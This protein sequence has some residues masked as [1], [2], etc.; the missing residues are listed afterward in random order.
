MKATVLTI[1]PQPSEREV[2][3]RSTP[4]NPSS[5]PQ[6]EGLVPSI[7]SV[8]L[9]K[10]L[11]E[12]EVRQGTGVPQLYRMEPPPA[13][14]TALI[15][16]LWS[17]LWILSLVLCAVVVK[18]L[19]SQQAASKIGTAQ[20]QSI[21]NLTAEIG[22]QKTEFSKM[23]DATR[24]LADVIASTS[25]RTASIP[26]MLERLANNL[27]QTAPATVTAPSVPAAAT[28]SVPVVVASVMPRPQASLDA[29]STGVPMGGHHHPPLESWVAP[30]DAVVH[31]NYLGVMDYCLFPRLVSGVWTMIKVV[32][33]GQ[34][35]RGTLVHDVAEVRDYLVTPSHDWIAISEAPSILG[36]PGR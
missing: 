35:P 26:G 15:R 11:A 19:D 21:N 7:E 6:A 2:Q 9:H 13:Q 36:L 14:R 12:L 17:A 10:L 18:Y 5:P 30:S 31:H 16:V 4:A 28:A 25:A 33:I 24:G 20:A 8:I 27:K 3:V 22:V 29:G 32:P 34:G 1:L 23:I